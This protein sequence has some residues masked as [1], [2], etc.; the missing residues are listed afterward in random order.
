VSLDLQYEFI[1]DWF[2]PKFSNPNKEGLSYELF[3]TFDK[4]DDVV[5]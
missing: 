2:V 1:N 5:N 3:N 4:K